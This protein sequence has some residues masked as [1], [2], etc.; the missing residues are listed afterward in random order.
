MGRR[1]G[2][3]PPRLRSASDEMHGQAG[4]AGQISVEILETSR[5]L[6][7]MSGMEEACWLLGRVSEEVQQEADL[8]G[9]MS[10][11]AL[12]VSLAYDKT[13]N[14][15]SIHGERGR[16]KFPVHRVAAWRQ[17]D[18]RIGTAWPKRLK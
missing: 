11:A 8:T 4:Q 9:R 7:R 1:F 14:E 10:D 16:Q 13:E 2:I 15:I 12:R 3:R 6:K 17:G 5:I 18:L